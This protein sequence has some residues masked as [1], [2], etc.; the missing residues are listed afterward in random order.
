VCNLKICRFLVARTLCHSTV[1]VKSAADEKIIIFV[2][3]PKT[4][5]TPNRAIVV[6]GQPFAATVFTEILSTAGGMR[7]NPRSTNLVC[8]MRGCSGG[9]ENKWLATFN[10]LGARYIW[11]FVVALKT[12]DK[13]FALLLHLRLINF[14]L[15]Q[16]ESKLLS[17]ITVVFLSDN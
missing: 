15:E 17:C 14:N 5:V 9:L 4:Y 12:K 11:R 2:A 6:S 8:N 3:S 1:I 13:K 7:T 10:D 16:S